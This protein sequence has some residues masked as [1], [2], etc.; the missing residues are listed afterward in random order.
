MRWSASPF[1]CLKI[2]KSSNKEVLKLDVAFCGIAFLSCNFAFLVFID[3]FCSSY[4]FVIFCLTVAR[5]VYHVSKL[6]CN[7][8]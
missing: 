4:V 3:F 8:Q 7:L 5:H 1:I 2:Q 6:S